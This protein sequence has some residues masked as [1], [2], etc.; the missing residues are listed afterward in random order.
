MAENDSETSPSPPTAPSSSRHNP[1]R[2]GFGLPLPALEP[3]VLLSSRYEVL[4]FLARGGMGEV[5]E[6][7]DLELGIS[8]ALKTIRTDLARD[9]NAL[10]RFKREV[11]LARSVSHPG[12]CRIYDFG[13]DQSSGRDLKFLTMELFRGESLR[14]RIQ[15]GGRMSPVE[16]LPL[17][18]QMAEALEAAHRAGVVHRD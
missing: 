8:V 3:G 18:R 16:A 6:A 2:D 5:Y 9:E 17:V 10:R 14:A 12:I 4:S 7:R 11:L 13:R 1:S 15:A